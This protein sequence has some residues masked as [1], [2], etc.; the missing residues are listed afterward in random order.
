MKAHLY[1]LNK[2]QLFLLKNLE[3]LK[4]YGINDFDGEAKNKSLKE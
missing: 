3:F 2:R 1:V 4:R